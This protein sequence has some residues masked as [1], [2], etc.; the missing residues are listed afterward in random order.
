MAE[1]NTINNQGKSPVM[2]NT[3]TITRIHA[4]E[5]AAFTKTGDPLDAKAKNWTGWSQSMRMLFDLFDVMEYVQ[6]KTPCPDSVV[7]PVGAKNWQY[8]DAFAQMLIT[9]NISATEKVYTIGCPTSHRM[10]LNLRSMHESHLFLTDH[11]RTLIAT[12]VAEGGN[13]HEHLTKL[14]HSWDQLSLFGDQNYRISDAFFKRIIAASLPPSWDQFTGP[15][16]SGPLDEVDTDPRKQINC[17][18]FIA[19]IRQASER[20]QS[21]T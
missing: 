3:P 4:A 8:N 12:T 1:D 9:S 19:I 16:V 11:F 13:I 18:Q 15:Y 7:D 14:E 10:W 20:E 17:Q 21:I 5:S 2:S 6:G